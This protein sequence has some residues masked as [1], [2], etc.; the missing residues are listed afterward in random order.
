MKKLVPMK[1]TNPLKT[2]D[3][4][5]ASTDENRSPDEGN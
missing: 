2:G 5:I 1:A 3:P 4:M